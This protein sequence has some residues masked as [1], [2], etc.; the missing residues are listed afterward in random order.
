VSFSLKVF[1]ELHFPQ[2]EG[3]DT[4]AQLVE[5]GRKTEET[6]ASLSE[7]QS[8]VGESNVQ[9]HCYDVW[10]KEQLPWRADLAMGSCN[11]NSSSSTNCCLFSVVQSST[12]V[13]PGKVLRELL[14]YRTN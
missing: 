9:L 1:S 13:S 3:S 14:R 2:R 8:D 4:N 10:Y 7:T 5:E 11:Y 6:D 12:G